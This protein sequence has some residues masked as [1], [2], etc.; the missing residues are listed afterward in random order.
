MPF[1]SVP[2]MEDHPHRPKGS[3]RVDLTHT[4]RPQ[5]Q[6][7]PQQV[8]QQPMSIPEAPAAAAATPSADQ[9]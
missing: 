9:Q 5:Q 1:C 6:L 3:N 4:Y 7:L 2:L 8:Q